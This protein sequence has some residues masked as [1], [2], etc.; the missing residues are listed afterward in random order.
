MKLRH[1]KAQPPSQRRAYARGHPSFDAERSWSDSAYRRPV[2]GQS[3]VGYS[4][5]TGVS[6]IQRRRWSNGASASRQI[7]PSKPSRLAGRGGARL[8]A[9]D[10]LVLPVER[11]N[12]LGEA[13]AVADWPRLA[14][15]GEAS[16][17][18]ADKGAAAVS[19][20]DVQ[21]VEVGGLM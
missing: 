4:S 18:L 20:V 1:L 17:S 14:E 13:V 7:G 6:S 11:A 21:L 10:G 9:A 19:A 15:D 3:L 8:R 2:T 16:R 5:A 12:G